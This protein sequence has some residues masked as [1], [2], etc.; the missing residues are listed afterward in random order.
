MISIIPSQSW[1][2]F[3]VQINTCYRTRWSTSDRRTSLWIIETQKAHW[4]KRFFSIFH[5][6]Y[7]HHILGI[8][9]NIWTWMKADFLIDRFCWKTFFKLLFVK[10]LRKKEISL[11]VSES[12]DSSFWLVILGGCL[13]FAC[14]TCRM[15]HVL[16]ILGILSTKEEKFK[17][18]PGNTLIGW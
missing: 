8:S 7:F 14:F 16:R 12:A 18:N 5:K 15:K 4:W 3:R 2:E 1:P 11:L 17:N 6:L 9:V 10:I 13:P